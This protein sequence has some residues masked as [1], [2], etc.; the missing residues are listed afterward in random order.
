MFS[1]IR[2]IFLNI[3]LLNFLFHFTTLFNLCLP[4]RF[5]F[6]LINLNL[7]LRRY[8]YLRDSSNL[9][10]SSWIREILLRERRSFFSFICCRNLLK[11]FCW[12]S[13]RSLIIPVI[14]F[15]CFNLEFSEL[16][17]TGSTFY[18]FFSFFLLVYVLLRF[19]RFLCGFGSSL[20]FGQF[21]CLFFLDKTLL[22]VFNFNINIFQFSY[23]NIK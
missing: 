17:V 7:S 6:F 10:Y 11:G 18:L 15:V 19:F 21:L 4:F 2:F 16:L 3:L 20:L 14:K 5:I 8:I 13:L 9:S 12:L 23:F 22:L 1:F